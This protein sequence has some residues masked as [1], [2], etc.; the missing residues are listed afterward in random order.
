MRR[1]EVGITEGQIRE[2]VLAPALYLSYESKS[3]LLPAK[4]PCQVS[5]MQVKV[6]FYFK[7][8]NFYLHNRHLAWLIGVCYASKSDVCD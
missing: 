4:Q 3:S 5:V 2:Q 7:N 8:L 6:M 1:K